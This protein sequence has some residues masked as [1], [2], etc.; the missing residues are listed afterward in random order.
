M[1]LCRHCCRIRPSRPRG[2][3]WSCYY[4][5]GVRGLYAALCNNYG[6]VARKGPVS[7]RPPAVPT[8]AMPG[9]D[10]KIDVLTARVARGEGLWHPKDRRLEA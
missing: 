4:R 7:A 9:S 2:L 6:G 3:C 8:D 1:T 5:P 10:E